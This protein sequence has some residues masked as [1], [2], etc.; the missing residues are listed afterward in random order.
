M[1]TADHRLS[2]YAPAAGIAVIAATYLAVLFTQ[3]ANLQVSLGGS[4]LLVSAG[5][6]AGAALILAGAIPH[7]SP[8]TLALMPLAVVVNMLM[9]QVVGVSGLPLYLD[10]LGTVFIALLAGPLAGAGTGIVTNLIWGAFNPSAIPFSAGAALVGLCAG[11]AGRLLR[12]SLGPTQ[13]RALFIAAGAA[14]GVLAAM[15]SAPVA[16]FLFGGGLG[17]GT[18][19]LV[20]ILQA[21]GLSMLSATTAQ[22]LLS[23]VADKALAFALALAAVYAM[24]PRARAR[25]PQAPTP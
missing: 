11:Y 16:A 15:I 5:Y 13:R 19:G 21:T 2:R 12:P 14:T 24:G 17:V 18:G 25:F 6:I 23:D 4:T 9:G 3:P 8:R 1:D 22:S 10:S 20:G 7:L